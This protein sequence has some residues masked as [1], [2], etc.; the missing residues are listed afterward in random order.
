MRAVLGQLPDL[1]DMPPKADDGREGEGLFMREMPEAFQMGRGKPMKIKLQR[2][3]NSWAKDG[4]S[5]MM[6]RFG[7]GW[8]WKLGIMYGGRTVIIDVLIGSIRI[9]F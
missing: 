8:R 9:E 7:G 4:W 6:E 3:G 2:F 5:R 1:S